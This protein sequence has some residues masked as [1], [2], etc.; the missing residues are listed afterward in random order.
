MDGWVWGGEG[1]LILDSYC[2]SGR[3]FSTNGSGNK[4]IK[5]QVHVVCNRQKL[6]GSYQVL[7]GFRFNFRAHRHILMAVLRSSVEYSCEVWSTN[8]C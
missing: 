2:C 3:E 4:N 7:Y 5:S 8:K 6:G 1:L